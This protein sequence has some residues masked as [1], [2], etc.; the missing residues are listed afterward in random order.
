MLESLAALFASL[1]INPSHM[2]AGLAGAFVRTVV[3]GNRMSWEIL[4]GS[5]VGAIC[6]IYLTPIVGTWLALDLANLAMNNGLAFAIGMIGM[7]LAEGLVRLA[8]RW[9]ENPRLMRSMD[10]QGLADAVND[11]EHTRVISD[12]TDRSSDPEQ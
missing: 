5:V 12:N 6:A 7:S 10:A 9:A 1:G 3:Q 4:L 8:Q 11:H 2:V